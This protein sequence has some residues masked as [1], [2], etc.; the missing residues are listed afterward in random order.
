[1]V[2][3]RLD[4]KTR[5][6]D[7]AYEALHAAIVSGAYE[8]GRRLQIRDLA[9]E[10]GISVMPV[11]EA[12]K[13]LEEVGLVETEPYRGA[14][15]KRLT[16]SELLQI[17]AVRRLLEVEAARLGTERIANGDVVELVQH[18]QEMVDTLE[19]GDIVNYLDMDEAVLLKIYSASGN[20]VLVDTIRS[21]WDRCRIYKIVGARDEHESGKQEHLLDYQ[22]KLLAAAREGDGAA[23]A[24]I[25]EDSLDAAI[26]RIH[27]A[28]PAEAAEV[29]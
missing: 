15:V 23:A 21:L 2:L 10:L 11:R 24:Q 27:L 25:T 29:E 12:I 18:Y 22:A 4:M 14:V 19:R 13:R 28:M 1:M 20:N 7:Q 16:R 3:S 6:G 17:Y 5:V 9:E 26:E 8:A